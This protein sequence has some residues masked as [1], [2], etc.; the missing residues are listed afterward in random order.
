MQLRT[1]FISEWVKFWFCLVYI[2]ENVLH[3]YNTQRIHVQIHR[4]QPERKQTLAEKK[5]VDDRQAMWESCQ[6]LAESCSS[7]H[8]W[9]L[10]YKSVKCL[11]DCGVVE[12]VLCHSL[13]WQ[14]TSQCHGKLSILLQILPRCLLLAVG[15]GTTLQQNTCFFHLPWPQLHSKKVKPHGL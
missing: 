10:V 9:M 13:Q 2:K 15:R 8:W 12:S 1:T 6:D 5:A 7:S 3:M 14:W 4:Q 11:I